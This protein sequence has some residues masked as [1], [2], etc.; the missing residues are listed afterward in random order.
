MAVSI[1]NRASGLG[2]LQYR[3][4][5]KTTIPTVIR[6]SKAMLNE[7]KHLQ[8]TL[9]VEWG[10]EKIVFSESQKGVG[11]KRL[12]W[13]REEDISGGE[14]NTTKTAEGGEMGCHVS[15]HLI[16]KFVGYK[17]SPRFIII[18]DICSFAHL[19]SKWF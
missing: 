6:E 18:E 1:I 2:N 11:C 8:N 4:E 16:V 3:I 10:T 7:L 9:G 15:G 17:K 19:Y 13:V 12:K 5:I 14:I